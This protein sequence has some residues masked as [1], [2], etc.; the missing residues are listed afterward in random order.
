MKVLV[1]SCFYDA[2]LPYSAAWFDGI[3]ANAADHDISVLAVDDG[4]DHPQRLLECAAPGIDATVI[5]VS[6]ADTDITAR[7]A[8]ARSAMLK[9]SYAS[10]AD[11]IVFCD[12]DDVL[13]PGAVARHVRVLENSDIAVGDLRVM[14]ASGMPHGDALFGDALPEMITSATLQNTNVCGF[15]N[16]AVRRETLSEFAV[17]ALPSLPALDWWLF[18]NLLGKGQTVRRTDG[19]VALYR[20]H[21]ANTLGAYM[22]TTVQD[23][24]RRL[25]IVAMHHEARGDM[26]R[27]RIA[28]DL[29]RNEDRL[30]HIMEHSPVITSRAWHADASSWCQVA[31]EIV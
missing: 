18:A 31:E 28:L 15:S 19:V 24:A 11:I 25:A 16:T 14:D 2:A 5:R 27:A 12:A 20:Q 26:H 17:A 3:R 29:S 30:R 10:D 1:A 7:I 4:L 23:A 9:A 8:T 6:E 22:A 21:D 13:T